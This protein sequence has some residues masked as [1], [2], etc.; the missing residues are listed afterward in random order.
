MTRRI[1]HHVAKL[2]AALLIS[3]SL[4]GCAQ[5]PAGSTDV[6]PAEG[7]NRGMFR[8]HQAIDG[9]VL[10]PVTYVYRGVVPEFGRDMVDNFV[11]NLSTPVVAANSFLQLDADRGFVAFWRFIINSTVGIGGLFD[12]ASE[13]GLKKFDNDFGL[14]MARYGADSGAYLFLPVLGPTSPRDLVGRVADMFMDPFN[15]YD[16]GATMVRGGL[17]ALNTRS[18]KYELLEDINNNSLDPY[19]TIRSGYTQSRDAE[20]RKVRGQKPAL[21]PMNTSAE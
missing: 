6:D 11:T 10:R 19:A 18:E 16:E 1:T 4:S 14:T 20:V 2:A 15:Y 13:A 9:A 21:K 7:F 3:A 8:V 17:T 12:V 5:A